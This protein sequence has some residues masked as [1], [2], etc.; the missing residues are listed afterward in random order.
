VQ[1]A[2]NTVSDANDLLCTAAA[3]PDG[4]TA[5]RHRTQVCSPFAVRADVL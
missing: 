1:L 3:G 5:T 4:S 2:F